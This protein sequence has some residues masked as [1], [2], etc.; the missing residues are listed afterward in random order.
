MGDGTDDAKNRMRE[1][2]RQLAARNQIAF[3]NQ[4]AE[5][6]T[7][8]QGLSQDELDEISPNVSSAADYASLMD[9]VKDASV[10]NMKVA[11]LKERIEALG[12]KAVAIARLVP[13]LAAILG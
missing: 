9:V 8:L 3:G 4:Y 1:E 2:L 11:E 5:E 13:K 6:L 7:A 12:Q 10:K